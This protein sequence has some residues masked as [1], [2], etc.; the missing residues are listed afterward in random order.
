MSAGLH[1]ISGCEALWLLGW[2][3]KAGDCKYPSGDVNSGC[4]CQFE[5]LTFDLVLLVGLHTVCH[6]LR[7]IILM[8]EDC[9][10]VTFRADSY[11]TIDSERRSLSKLI[12]SI[13]LYNVKGVITTK[14]VFFNFTFLI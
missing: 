14:K 12:S 7:Y 2:V 10:V 11:R 8:A 9:T 13:L 1:T 6:D 3:A 5:L 4:E